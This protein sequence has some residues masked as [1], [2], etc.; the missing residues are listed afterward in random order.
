MKVFSIAAC[1]AVFAGPSFADVRV[2]FLERAPKDTFIVTNQGACA[3]GTSELV[4]DFQGTSAGL[5]FDVSGSGAGVEVFQPFEVTEGADFLTSLPTISD[6]DQT[7]TL[8]INNLDPAQRIAFTIDVDDTNG[9][10]EIT[11]SDSEIN[12]ATATLITA[13]DRVSS[14]FDTKA[15]LVLPTAA[16]LS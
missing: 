4:I 8:L 9:V 15:E 11:V 16:C 10:R 1:A 12:G 6:G 7:A 2:Q 3:I 14:V 13:R 5:I